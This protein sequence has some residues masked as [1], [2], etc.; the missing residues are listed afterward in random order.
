M[1]DYSKPFAKQETSFAPIK[2]LRK[3]ASPNVE[4]KNGCRYD[5]LTGA[6]RRTSQTTLRCFPSTGKVL[7]GQGKGR[8]KET[9]QV[10]V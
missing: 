8:L 2:T 6:I 10:F 4:Q 9:F 3:E 1:V 5:P 7:S